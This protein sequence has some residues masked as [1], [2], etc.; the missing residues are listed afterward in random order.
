MK[1]ALKVVAN[2]QF[3]DK[4]KKSE[5]EIKMSDLLRFYAAINSK[6]F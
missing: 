3:S 6:V 4:L 2:N 1:F 5:N